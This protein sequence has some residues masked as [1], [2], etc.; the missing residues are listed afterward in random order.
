MLIKHRRTKVPASKCRKR[1]SIR[2]RVDSVKWYERNFEPAVGKS[3]RWCAQKL[4]VAPKTIRNWLRD[5]EKMRSYKKNVMS[6][7]G[8]PPSQLNI[9][10]HDILKFIFERREQGFGV[11]RHSV[12][13][14]ASNLMP[15]FSV[16]SATAKYSA[17]RRFLDSHDLVYRLGTHQS[18]KSPMLAHDDAVDFVKIMRP[19]LYGPSRDPKYILNMDQTPVYYSMHEKKTLNKKGARTVNLRTSKQD[20]E[21]I[22]VAVTISAAGD[23]LQPTVIFKGKK[24]GRIE[25]DQLKKLPAG[26]HYMVQEKA[27]MDHEVMHVWVDVVLKPYIQQAPKGI[28]PV[29]FLDSYRAHMMEEIVT[30]IQD[31]GVEV[32]HIPGGCTGLIQPVDVGF[33][34]PFKSRIRLQW[35]EWMVSK[36]DKITAADDTPRPNRHIVSEWVIN[37]FSEVPAALIRNAWTKTGYAWFNKQ[38]EIANDD[39]AADGEKETEEDEDELTASLWVGED[40]GAV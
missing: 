27:W 6:M 29:L 5:Y 16:K 17:M 33:N 38:H 23:L 2:E 10:E 35:E 11:S 30:K 28:I 19:F 24:G 15:S 22:T 31:L 8:G 3:Q 39:N 25:K 18:Q 34:K 9:I 36:W 13:M 14:K 40:V 21:R 1:F 7:K 32:L 20:S 4:N 12:V 26:P 37:A